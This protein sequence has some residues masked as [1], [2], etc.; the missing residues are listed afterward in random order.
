MSDLLERSSQLKQALVDF[1]LDAEGELAVALETFSKDKFEEWSKVQTQSQNHSAMAIDMFLSDGRVN[2][3]TPIDCFI[4]ETPDL[5]ESDRTLLKSW[6]HSF[7]GLF[8]VIQVSDSAYDLMNWLTTKLYRVSPNGRQ[9]DAKLSRLKV[10]EMVLTRIAPLTEGQWIFSGPME[11]LGKLGKPKLA[12]AIGNFR[13]RFKQH[14]YGDAPELLEESWQSVEIYHQEFVDFFGEAEITMPGRDFSQRFQD[15]QET[16]SENQLQRAGIDSSKSLQDLAQE[17]G[18]SQEAMEEMAA[19][20]DGTS[21]VASQ[22]LNSGKS[23]KMVMPKVDLPKPLQ[24]AEQL[25]VIVHPRWG[26]CLLDDYQ[27]LCDRLS[28]DS[29]SLETEALDKQVKRYLE[30]STIHPYIWQKLVEHYPEPLE[31]ALQRVLEQ[32]DFQIQTDLQATLQTYGKPAEPELPETASVPVHLD[33]LF[34]EA[35]AEVEQPKGKGK[36][37]TKAKAKTGFGAR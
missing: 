9:E 14:L 11:L 13:D 36:K 23:I 33:T 28:Q 25:T 20:L 16:L 10:G 17:S 24:R 27:V 3:K 35:L 7:N 6:N 29:D 37:K 26:N 15:F 4:D 30:E 1:I 22:L 21:A 19:E 8:E 2:D 31:T 12:V 32:P 5:S 34:K 18:V